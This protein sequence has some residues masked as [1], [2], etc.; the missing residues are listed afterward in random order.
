MLL[1]SIVIIAAMPGGRA[2]HY[3]AGAVWALLAMVPVA[4]LLVRRQMPGVVE[5]MTGDPSLYLQRYR[6][7]RSVLPVGIPSEALRQTPGYGLAVAGL[8]T[9][10]APILA[11]IVVIGAESGGALSACIVFT[12]LF[13]FGLQGL[14]EG[15]VWHR[16]GCEGLEAETDINPKQVM[17]EAGYRWVAPLGWLKIGRP[18]SL[19]DGGPP[20]SLGAEDD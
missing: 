2:L 5:V 13:G 11:I 8:A 10:V 15:E 14:C 12:F 7:V 19:P 1:G 20:R 6:K 3:M 18:G 16:Y 17:V 9:F 4:W